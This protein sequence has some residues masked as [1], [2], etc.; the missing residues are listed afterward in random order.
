MI[1]SICVSWFVVI[2]NCC[3]LGVF[4]LL[5]CFSVGLVVWVILFVVWVFVFVVWLCMFL[6]YIHVI[7]LC[8]GWVGYV[9]VILCVVCDFGGLGFCCGFVA[10]VLWCFGGCLVLG[11]ASWFWG[12]F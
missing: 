12:W 11:G 5:C 9:V 10:W 8:L 1:C 6:L 4:G 3:V 2:T 7:T